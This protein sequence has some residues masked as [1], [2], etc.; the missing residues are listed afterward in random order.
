MKEQGT[1]ERRPAQL[2]PSDNGSTAFGGHPP[3][4]LDTS[5][6]VTYKEKKDAYHAICMMKVRYYRNENKKKIK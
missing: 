5:Y 4:K 6:Q 1:A 2:S 3:P